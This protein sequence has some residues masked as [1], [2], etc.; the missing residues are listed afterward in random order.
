[1][2]ETKQEK[3]TFKWG[4]SEYLLDDLLK[5]HAEQEQN[6]YNF[7]KAKG[8]Y[9][10]AALTGLRSALTNRINAAKS[11]KAFSADGLLDTD[12]V[13]N[14]SIQTQKKGL[15]KKEKYVEQDNTEW[16]KYYLNKLVSQLKPYQREDT[17]SSKDWDISKHGFEA[18]L[19]GQGLDAREVFEKYDLRDENNPDAA[20]SYTQRDEQLRKH[21]GNYKTWL[22]NKGF[23]FTKNDNE[24]DDNY[25]STLDS[26]INGDWNDRTALA[27][28]LRKL[29][30][31]NYALAFTSDKWD[32]SK[33]DEE[34]SEESKKRKEE[35]AAKQKQIHMDEFENFAYDNRRPNTPIYYKGY[36][37]DFSMDWYG[38]LNATQQPEYGTYLGRDNQAWTKAWTNLMN[39]LKSGRS[40]SDKN[41]GVLL[42][43]TFLNQNHGFIDLGDGKYLIRDS[44]TDNGQGTVYDPNTG[45]TNTVFLGDL[46]GNNAEIH[47]IYR[48]LAYKYANNK[49][50]TKY[51]DRP[52]VLRD[53]G[54]L[55]PKH[56]YGNAVVF[57]WE[58]SNKDT[59]K[60]KA[61]ENNLSPEVQK[62]RNRYIDSDN[63]SI[64][65]PD[66]GFTGA[67]VARLAS[68][69]ADI[70]S[71]FLDPITGTAIGLGSTLTNF[72]ADIADDGFQWE[73]VKNLGI[74]V[75]FDLLGAIPIFGDAIG[76]GGKIT[77]NLLKFGPRIMA[78]LAAYQGVTNFDGMMGSWE[79]MISSDEDA[80]MT[81][82]DWRNIA[83]SISLV[84]GAGR[85]IKNKAAQNAMKNKARVDDVVG[86]NVYDKST[87]QTKQILVDGETAKNIKA[88]QGDRAK[89]EAEL[90]KLE[91]FKDK[92]GEA[93][94]LEVLTKG[95][96][97][98]QSPI[99]RATKADGSKS[100]EL[101]PMRGE[102][103]AQVTDVY[104]FS[105]VPEGYGS[106]WGKQPKWGEK[107]TRWHQGQMEQ[108]NKR[109]TPSQENHMGALTAVEVDAQ[110]KA[111]TD[112]LDAQVESMKTAMARRTAGI[113]ALETKTKTTLSEV[114]ALQSKL[115]GLNKNTVSSELT[116][117]RG[118]TK[119]LRSLELEVQ[120]K[121]QQVTSLDSQIKA[122][123]QQIA[124]EKSKGLPTSNLEAR[125]N[126]L[127][128]QLTASQTQLTNI[129]TQL[130]ALKTSS[131]PKLQRQAE[132]ESTLNDFEQLRILQARLGN[133]HKKSA[134]AATTNH[135]REYLKLEQM[136]KDLQ[137]NHSNVGGRD[138]QWDMSDILN[139]ASIT[140]A[141][142]TGGNINRNKINKFLSYAKR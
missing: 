54:E 126:N 9:D 93:G 85:A 15:F 139:R 135:T 90:S 18:Y 17:T 41:A 8:S 25:M 53:G 5:L 3:Q 87:K 70:T 48:Q 102:G 68:I 120:S 104:D 113:D 118:A 140:N 20:R 19:K 108:I 121:K 43:G 4:D 110:V 24:W 38:D 91:D 128:T 92:F 111:L 64:D 30:S 71:M 78:G 12:T 114:K 29:G 141:F 74:N 26:V 77:K 31:G 50:G 98:L 36:D 27:A 97:P 11:G 79:K 115:R 124:L 61:K 60:E 22:E 75:G 103:R 130:T 44:V 105:R 76:T 6:F 57:N 86:I 133:L 34:L 69:G 40:Y 13:D 99:H 95:H 127:E 84:T 65:N 47:N 107:L 80:K 82:Q 72:G 73:D 42:Q 1:M 10:N 129:E 28:S 67:E 32:L 137:T 96:G 138:V 94:T 117:L 100:F 52:D 132:L 45:Y 136:L 142:K 55:I 21:L 101:R 89:V 56:Q 119:G 2:A 83:Q 112:P 51:E 16:A 62:A 35:A 109:L 37:G 23:D 88:A 66:A 106:F 39:S 125:K 123:D 7:A 49:Y 46:A 33:S 131:E 134:Q 116:G 59:T 14:T 58:S 63:K 81:V 122:L